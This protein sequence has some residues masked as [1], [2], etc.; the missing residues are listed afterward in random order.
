MQNQGLEEL[1]NLQYI[2]SM[3]SGM[4]VKIPE[5]SRGE[6]LK[7]S[8]REESSQRSRHVDILTTKTGEIGSAPQLLL[9]VHQKGCLFCL[10]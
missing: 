2:L 9:V 8:E 5:Q 10:F 3:Y 1:L 4:N 6:E 7:L